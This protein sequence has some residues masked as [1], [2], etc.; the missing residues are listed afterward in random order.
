V[1]VDGDIGN[2]R[3]WGHGRSGDRLYGCVPYRPSRIL[4][5]NRAARASFRIAMAQ[6]PRCSATN[7]YVNYVDDG[8]K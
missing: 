5:V 6:E 8:G 7:K 3:R 4:D 1:F 2:R